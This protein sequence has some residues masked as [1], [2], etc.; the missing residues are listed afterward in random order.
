MNAI[1]P[2][3]PHEE[4]SP[5]AEESGLIRKLIIASVVV[6]I[7][8]FVVDLSGLIDPPQLKLEELAIETDFISEQDLKEQSAKAIPK[9]KPNPELAVD[10]KT[11]P[12]LPKVFKIKEQQKP[13]APEGE[14]TTEA[15][16][17][18]KADKVD[19]VV[20]EQ[21]KPET[22]KTDPKPI[23]ALELS[24]KDALR[25]L[26]LERLRTDKNI[27]NKTSP[28][29][30]KDTPE[31]GVKGKDASN[32]ALQQVLTAGAIS[33]A[34]KKTYGLRLK[35]FISPKYNIPFTF[36]TG[37]EFLE[38]TVGFVLESNGRLN[39]IRV[40]KGS[41]NRRFDE[42]V[43]KILQAITTYPRPPLDLAGRE[44]ELNFNNRTKS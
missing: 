15:A 18:K 40:T 5:H 23:D 36:K 20:E 29:A 32:K 24:K 25:R 41:G 43:L 11:L 30:P 33:A 17:P 12:Q 9:A 19:K 21:T 27:K 44:F 31:V 42:H 37:R 26:A 3:I 16:E 22:Q 28:S 13:D 6:H 4:T 39:K 2:S 34:D 35:R 1:N 7:A 8:F 38:V 14:T 10:K